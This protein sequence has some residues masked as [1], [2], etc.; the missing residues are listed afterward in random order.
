MSR[1][2]S[3]KRAHS[4]RWARPFVRTNPSSGPGYREEL[5]SI[6]IREQ[7]VG[8]PVLVKN[9]L[10]GETSALRFYTAAPDDLSAYRLAAEAVQQRFDREG[11]AAAARA[12]RP[13]SERARERLDRFVEE[14]GIMVTTGQ[15]AGLLTGPLYTIYKALT[16]VRLAERLEQELGL[17]VIPVF[18]TA[19]EDHDWAEVN[20]TFLSVSGD[21][22]RRVDLVDPPPP[23]TPMSHAPLGEGVRNIID[24]ASDILG[25]EGDNQLLIQWIQ[26]AY[27]AS[28]SVAGSFASLLEPML[29]PFDVCMT[30]AAHPAVKEASR[31]VMLHA[32]REAERHEVLLSQ[33]TTALEAAGYHGQ[34]AVLPGGANVFRRGS[35]GR[36]RLYRDAG[37][38]RGA[39]SGEV[40]TREEV[41]TE[42]AA[43][44]S[45]YSPNVFLRPVVESAVF[46]TVAY[47]GGPG[48]INYFAQLGVLFPEFGMRAPIVYPRASLLLVELPIQRLLG[49][50]ALEPEALEQPRHELVEQLAQGSFPDSLRETLTTLDRQIADGYRELIEGAV[51]ID[52][53]LEGALARL[54]NE[55]LARI[56]DSER[57]ITQHI[58]R[59]EGVR[60]GQLDRLLDNLRPDGKPQDRVLNVI[61]YLARHGLSLLQRM[62]EA[63]RVEV[64]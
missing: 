62:Y 38:F 14:G 22:T 12:L 59:R 57:K 28:A 39:E 23:A 61:P 36:E 46:P 24:Q 16:A 60:I 48:E 45:R 20:H 17:L 50:L 8:G 21:G 11:R 43:D 58:K 33:R 40:L 6:E 56:G 9:Y 19:S 44:P 53:T 30:D 29:A 3:D 55:A 63:I 4:S 10:R 18:W 27:T 49:K 64:R 13:T 42:L 35:E 41:E 37:G 51:A 26:D 31:G 54:R 34:V 7:P 32:L 5:L 2:T 52:P 15:Q 47:V 1:I 25:G